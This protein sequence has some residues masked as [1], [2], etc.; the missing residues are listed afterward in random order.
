[1]KITSETLLPA[2]RESRTQVKQDAILIKDDRVYNHKLARFYYTTY[3][4]RRAEDIINPK[5]THCNVMLLSDLKL[6]NTDSFDDST[7]HPFIYARVLGIYHVNVI[8]IGPHSKGYDPMRFEFLHVRWFQLDIP[9]Q[10]RHQAGWTS[11]RLDCLSFPPTAEEDSFGFLD[12]S[13]VL[14]TCH[15]I[16]AFNSG[17]RHADGVGLSVMASNKTDYKNYYINR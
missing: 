5:T 16:P 1:M 3:D 13:L 4:V 10:D 17:K 15:V 9:L 2:G 7:A 6:K 8:Y 11:S 12:P 14:R